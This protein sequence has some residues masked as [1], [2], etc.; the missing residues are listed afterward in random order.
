[1]LPTAVSSSLF[2]DISGNGIQI[3]TIDSY[4]ISHASMQDADNIVMDSVV[5]NVGREWLGTCGIIAFYS[6]GTRILHNEVSHV[7]YTGISIGELDFCV[8]LRVPVARNA[9]FWYL[10][11]LMCVLCCQAGAGLGPWR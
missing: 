8:F 10:N 3:G 6:R 1:M 4:N 9:A 7:P 5:R 11:L 2:E